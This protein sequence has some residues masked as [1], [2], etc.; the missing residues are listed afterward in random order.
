MLINLPLLATP[1]TRAFN[2]SHLTLHEGNGRQPAHDVRTKT[3]HGLKPTWSL[4]YR[5]ASSLL[6]GSMV[7]SL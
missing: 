7:D 1:L 2:V 3:R 5:F 4:L 6:I